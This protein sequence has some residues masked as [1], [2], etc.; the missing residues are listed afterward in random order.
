MGR[1]SRNPARCPC[2]HTPCWPPGS[3]AAGGLLPSMAI[4]LAGGVRGAIAET[5]ESVF[6]DQLNQA[7]QDLARDIFLRLTEL[8]EGTKI[9]AGGR[10]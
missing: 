4:T 6:T 1:G 7:Q 2:F 5:A 8:G 3:A 10:P 9:P